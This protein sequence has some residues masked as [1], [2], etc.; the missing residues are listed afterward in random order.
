MVKI[1]ELQTHNSSSEELFDCITP[2]FHL[3]AVS[4][5]DGRIMWSLLFI[6]HFVGW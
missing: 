5:N 4:I 1:R 2:L 3:A 6:F